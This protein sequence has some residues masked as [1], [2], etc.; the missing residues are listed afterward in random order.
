MSYTIVEPIWNAVHQRF[1][2]MV[3]GL[4]EQELALGQDASSI[5]SMLIHNAEVEYLFSEWFFGVPVPEEIKAKLAGLKEPDA[6]AACTLPEITAFLESSNEHL[7]KAMRNLTE[8]AWAV[9][10]QSS[11]GTS[12]PLEVI[13]RLIYHTGIH[14]G[15]I[16]L[17]RKNAAK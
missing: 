10:V 15:Q 7:H 9:P 16:S 8:D 1:M 13:G 3:S 11:Y 2:K 12:A 4:S 17:I 6:L 5:A 14:S